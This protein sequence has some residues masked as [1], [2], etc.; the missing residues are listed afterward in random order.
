M[1]AWG[2]KLDKSPTPPRYVADF[3]DGP[4]KLCVTLTKTFAHTCTVIG[5]ECWYM[6][7]LDRALAVWRNWGREMKY[8]PCHSFHTNNFC[9]IY[10]SWHNHFFL[11]AKAA[12]T[13]S[14]ALVGQAE[15]RFFAVFKNFTP[16]LFVLNHIGSFCVPSLRKDDEKN[17]KFSLNPPQLPFHLA[18]ECP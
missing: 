18:V 5:C 1:A 8:Y 4:A 13:V 11:S 17:V 2:Q 16:F 3:F 12:L 7:S 6:I 15:I 14:P 9:N 10:L